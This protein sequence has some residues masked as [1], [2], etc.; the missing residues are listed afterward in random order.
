MVI[1]V[2]LLTVKRQIHMYQYNYRTLTETPRYV[3]LR[4]LM[5]AGPS[6]IL[7]E[8]KYNQGKFGDMKFIQDFALLRYL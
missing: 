8:S 5:R 6:S 2:L 4:Y 3:Q 1:H 7:Y